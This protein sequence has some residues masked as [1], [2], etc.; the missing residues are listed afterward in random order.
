MCAISEVIYAFNCVFK[1]ELETG[2]NSGRPM[3]LLGI[4][5]SI[6]LKLTNAAL[7]MQDKRTTGTLRLDGML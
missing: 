6:V 3:V 7:P 1:L 2:K 4:R 5:Q